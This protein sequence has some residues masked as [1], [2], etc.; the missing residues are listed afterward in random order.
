MEIHKA[1][2][3]EAKRMIQF[4]DV[5]EEARRFLDEWYR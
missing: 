4:K 2:G 5:V 1:F 3:Y